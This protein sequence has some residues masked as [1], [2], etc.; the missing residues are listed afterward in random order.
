MIWVVLRWTG[1]IFFRVPTGFNLNSWETRGIGKWNGMAKSTE[2][3]SDRVCSVLSCVRLFGT[4]RSVAHQAPLS[5]GLL[6]AR[7]LE[8]VAMPSSRG[9]SQPR[10]RTQVSCIAGR[11]FTIWATREIQEV[12]FR[13]RQSGFRDLSL[14]HWIGSISLNG[15]QD[16][17]CPRQVASSIWWKWLYQIIEGL[18]VTLQNLDLTH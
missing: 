13:A 14:D 18:R 10:D 16:S 6:Q 17:C 15:V 1:Q 11:F 3:V 7:I 9:S 12:P 8:W 4:P 5:M 2:L